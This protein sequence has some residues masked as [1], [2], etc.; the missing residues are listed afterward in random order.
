LVRWGSF[1]F[2][3]EDLFVVFA[4]WLDSDL[5]VVFTCWLD[6]FSAYFVHNF[7][8]KNCAK[9]GLNPDPDLD[10]EPEQEPKLF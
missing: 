10:P 5:F 1:C 9:Y 4:C 6:V 2:Q 8:L 3:D 7:Y